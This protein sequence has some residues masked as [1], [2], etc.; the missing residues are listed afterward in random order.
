MCSRGL[1][2]RPYLNTFDVSG[3]FLCL[4]QDD[5]IPQMTGQQHCLVS[6]AAGLP[7]SQFKAQR[8][9]FAKTDGR[10]RTFS[11]GLFGT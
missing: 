5:V 3:G 2:L 9:L 1:Y 4:L 6:L 11:E 10:Y 7:F 8:R